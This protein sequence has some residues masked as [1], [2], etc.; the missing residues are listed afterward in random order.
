MD[1]ESTWEGSSSQCKN[2]LTP[3]SSHMTASRMVSELGILSKE[4]SLTSVLLHPAG[5]L[6]PQLSL[7]P[8]LS[9]LVPRVK[10]TKGTET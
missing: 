3:T 5:V 10:Q 1:I 7:E 8:S 6:I 9:P 4:H 2:L